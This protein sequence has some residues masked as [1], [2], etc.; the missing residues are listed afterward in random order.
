MFPSS[1]AITYKERTDG[2]WGTFRT[3]TGTVAYLQTKARLGKK[4]IDNQSRLT[5]LLCPVREVLPVSTM[6]FNQLLQRDLD[7]H[8]VATE[9]IPYLLTQGPTG[10][11]FFPPVMAVLLPFKGSDPAEAFPSPEHLVMQ[12]EPE[13]G[14]QPFE[15]WRFGSAFRFQRLCYSSGEPHAVQFGRLQWNSEVAKLVVLDGQHRAMALLAINRTINEG[16]WQGTGGA[17]YRHFYEYR[18][19]ELLK[20]LESQ[21]QDQCVLGLTEFPV[22]ICW[23]PEYV[24]DAKEKNP[25]IAARKIF[26]D[27][28]KNARL[29]SKARLILLSDTELVNVFTRAMLNR[30][31]SPSPPFPLYAVEYDNPNPDATQSV[32]WS[33]FTNLNILNAAVRAAVFGPP[34][35]I[36]NVS[37]SFQGRLS[38]SEMDEFMRKQLNLTDLLPSTIPEGSDYSLDREAIGN[39][40][41]PHINRSAQEQI[42][43]RFMSTWGEAIL[44]LLGNLLPYWRHTQA[45]VSLHDAW[46]TDDAV[47]D[48]ARDAVFEG[49]GIYWTLQD[50]HEHW[51]ESVSKGEADQAIV[52]DIVKSWKVLQEKGKNFATLRAHNFLGSTADQSVKT[53][54]AA[55]R[56]MNT[57][58]CQVGAVLAL[59]SIARKHQDK[60]PV[61]LARML[62]SAWNAALEGGPAQKRKRTLLLSREAKSPL[63]TV[64][65]LDSP[66][67]VYFRYIFFQ[68]LCADEARVVIGDKLNWP[69]ILDLVSRARGLY[70]HFLVRQR[71]KAFRQTHPTLNRKQREDKAQK[72]VRHELSLSLRTWFSLSDDDLNAWFDELKSDASPEGPE[73][74]SDDDLDSGDQEGADSPIPEAP[75]GDW[76]GEIEE[77]AAGG[78]GS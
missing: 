40:K 12:S 25:H 1:Q 5:A 13:F 41:F 48:L 66:Q 55:Y 42:I 35:Y 20:R 75:S 15:E 57:H 24:G 33:V 28:N 32:R 45:I 34:K 11:A 77:L 53:S 50:S 64:P 18:V 65:K 4:D 27:V 59:A 72:E 76:E 38:E 36:D 71:A 21:G 44:H 51:V 78:S 39:L 3:P 54:E 46:I 70:F 74:G 56:T 17:K 47:G 26:V 52:P 49:V 58:A 60:A 10:P 30:L 16:G 8:R 37:L 7:D 29:P 6:N 9:L 19:K 61:D 23:F 2:T 68:L 62:V 43:S 63:N 22:T 67:S 73:G 69:V 14:N 31:R